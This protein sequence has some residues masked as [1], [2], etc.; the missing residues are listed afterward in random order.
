MRGFHKRVSAI[1]L[2]SA[3]KIGDRPSEYQLRMIPVF[4]PRQARAS[5]LGSVLS[6]VDNETTARPAASGF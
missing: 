2:F 5:W 6:D 3:S 4:F 1:L